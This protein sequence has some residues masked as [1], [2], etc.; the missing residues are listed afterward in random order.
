M[1]TDS[2]TEGKNMFPWGSHPH[3]I[4]EVQSS[5]KEVRKVEWVS[6]VGLTHTEYSVYESIF[7]ALMD[8]L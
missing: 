2:D 5:E 7:L 8:C 3:R 4:A 6:S 1:K